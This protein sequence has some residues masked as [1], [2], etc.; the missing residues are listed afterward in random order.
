[1]GMGLRPAFA[2]GAGLQV[3][4]LV[5]PEDRER[6]DLVR[7]REPDDAPPVLAVDIR[8]AER[9]RRAGA[10]S[11]RSRRMTR[12]RPTSAASATS[13]HQWIVASH[14]FGAADKYPAPRTTCACAPTIETAI[15]HAGRCDC[16]S[17]GGCR[18]A[19]RSRPAC[20]NTS[21]PL[22]SS[23]Y[24][25]PDTTKS[26]STVSVVC[27]PGFVGSWTFGHPGQSFLEFGERGG[28]VEVTR[29]VAAFAGPS[30]EDAEAKAAAAAGS[31]AARRADARRSATTAGHRSPTADGTPYPGSSETVAGSTGSSLTNTDLPSASDR[32]RPAA[33]A[34]AEH[35]PR[36]IRPR[37]AVARPRRLGRG[38]QDRDQVQRV[39][40]DRLGVVGRARRRPRRVA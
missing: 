37:D 17:G 36:R 19:R 33:S 23:R 24:T 6:R 18:S 10:R 5:G 27:I 12:S 25:S 1:M 38:R 7:P 34:C 40:E 9:R 32:S 14:A 39:V 22:S 15:V 2:V 28:D 16:S 11:R 26:K 31:T 3:Q 29:A 8:R 4:V 30:G 21:A 20:S 13:A 35:E